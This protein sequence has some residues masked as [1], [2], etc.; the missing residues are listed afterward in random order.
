MPLFSICV[1]LKFSKIERIL[2]LLKHLTHLNSGHF[3]SFCYIG[4]TQDN[5]EEIVSKG[6]HGKAAHLI[7]SDVDHVAVVT[8]VDVTALTAKSVK[9][10]ICSLYPG[11]N[12]AGIIIR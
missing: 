2:L 11:L 12:A 1:V 4:K 7:L 9:G 8:P 6:T 5:V 3:I 10:K